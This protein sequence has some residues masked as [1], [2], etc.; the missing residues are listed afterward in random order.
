MSA[1]VSLAVV[2]LLLVILLAPLYEGIIRKLKALVHSRKGPPLQQPYLDLLKLLGKEDLNVRGNPLFALGPVLTLGSVFVAALL[3]PMGARAPFGFAGDLIVLVYFLTLASVGVM[4]G[5]VAT[6]SPYGAIGAGRE[7]MLAMVSEIILIGSLI[8]GVI[9]AQSFNLAQISTWYHQAGPT[10][11]MIIAAL[12]FFLILQVQLGKLPFD[13]PDADQ[14]IMGGPFMEAAGP[15]LALYKWSYFAKQI[16]LA[17]IFW[18]IF[19]PWLKTGIAPLDIAI[20]LA[21]V[22][23]VIVLVGVIDAVN[24]RIR[25]DQAIRYFLGILIV[26]I[27]AVAFALIGV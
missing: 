12:S 14:E 22:L 26:L 20:N 7:M 9:H 13:I 11:S 5:G 10:I 18:E 17:S 21:K 1:T 2:N 6:G 16:I 27:F 3:T 8:V 23:L 19:F 24:P 15:K 25:V 4:L